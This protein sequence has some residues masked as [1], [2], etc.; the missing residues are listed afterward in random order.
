MNAPARDAKDR[1]AAIAADYEPFTFAGRQVYVH[2]SRG[3]GR[4][5]LAEKFSGIV[6]VSSTVR[7][8]RTIEKVVELCS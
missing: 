6:G 2:Y 3:L 4:S 1:V 7:N 8:I 5:K